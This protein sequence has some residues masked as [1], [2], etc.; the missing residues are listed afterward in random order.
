MTCSELLYLSLFLQTSYLQDIHFSIANHLS[1]L[2]VQIAKSKDW[3]LPSKG[4]SLVCWATIQLPLALLQTFWGRTFSTSMPEKFSCYVCN[5]GCSAQELIKR[6]KA[7]VYFFNMGMLG[8]NT[9]RHECIIV[10][11]YYLY[12]LLP[13]PCDLRKQTMVI[14]TA[15]WMDGLNCESMTAERRMGCSVGYTQSLFRTPQTEFWNPNLDKTS[16]DEPGL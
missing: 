6:H 16:K 4:D 5:W 10:L 3:V 12:V 8:G 15:P 2:L 1:F 14:S 9:Q 7:K 13:K 11:H